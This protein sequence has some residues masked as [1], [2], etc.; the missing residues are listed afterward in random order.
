ML[1]ECEALL[2]PHGAAP[3][4]T[5]CVCGTVVFS[6]KRKMCSVLTEL[7]SEALR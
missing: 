1:S 2:T 6:F 3:S 5:P 4:Q 7:A